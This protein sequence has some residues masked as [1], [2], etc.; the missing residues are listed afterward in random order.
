[1]AGKIAVVLYGMLKTMPPYDA[2]KHRKAMGLPEPKLEVS[3]SPVEAPEELVETLD[4]EQD[5][6]GDIEE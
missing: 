4:D 2:K 3:Q 5:L 1:M 6:L